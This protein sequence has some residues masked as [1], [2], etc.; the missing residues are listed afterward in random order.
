M[1]RPEL[2]KKINPNF[3][4]D[5]AKM[6]GERSPKDH[7]NHVERIM[8]AEDHRLK[9]FTNDRKVEEELEKEL[10]QFMMFMHKKKLN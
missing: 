3:F 6:Y 4:Y 2:L 7:E 1:K 5:Y 10:K 9:Q 8:N